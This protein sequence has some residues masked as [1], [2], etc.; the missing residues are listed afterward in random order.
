MLPRPSVTNPNVKITLPPPPT[1]TTVAVKQGDVTLS[2]Q[3]S[4]QVQSTEV[5]NLYFTNGGRVTAVAV[6][7]G[8]QVK[9][10]QVLAS[11][12]SGSLPYDIQGQEITIKRD[13]L[14][15]TQIEA[16][17]QANPPLNATEAEQQAVQLDQAQLA[18]Q[19]DE[20]T[21]SNQQ[22]QL[23]RDEVVAPF[24]GVVNDIVIVPGDAVS[25]YQ[26]VMDISDPHT[27]A[28][29]AHPDSTTA[30]ELT[31]G[32]AFTMTM[33]T[34]S[35]GTYHGTIA[36]VTV[37]TQQQIA[38]AEAT[39]NP[40]AIPQPEAVLD[41][42]DYPGSPPL[43]ATFSATIILN[44]AK[45][46]LYVPAGVVRVFGGSA[47]VE[48]FQ[49]GAIIDQPVKVGLEGDTDWQISSGVTAGEEVVE[50]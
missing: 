18:L 7:N 15:I 27:L 29:V 11:L 5:Q 23:A 16:Q 10:G 2:A 47:Y 48:L 37:P 12:D 9:A 39:G 3:L 44:Q 40:N 24:S 49:N 50:P 17:D 45:N 4:G 34:G 35:A 13:Q 14:N 1:P 28:F 30:S 26:V 31:V 21:L 43:G 33:N 46:V 20:N 41:V 6:R 36:Q 42:T 19:Q 32:A 8:Q 38:A 25:S 22:Q